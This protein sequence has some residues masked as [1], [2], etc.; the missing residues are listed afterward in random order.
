MGRPAKSPEERHTESV[1]VPLRPS[2]YARL[3][4]YADQ[5][6]TSVTDFVRAS[7]LGH[8][9]TVVKSDAPDPETLDQLR[10]I[11]V[12]LNQ[13]AKRMNE[14]KSVSAPDV[15]TTLRDLQTLLARWMFDDP[16][17]HHRQKL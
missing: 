10:R 7:A 13:I 4:S 2:D 6:S 12:N 15:E 9:F 17:H 1:R 11:G 3:Q 8:E 14:Y 5:A 16:A